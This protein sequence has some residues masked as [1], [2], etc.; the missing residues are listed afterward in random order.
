M[1]RILAL[2]LVLAL[3]LPVFSLAES[4]EEDLNIEDIIEDVDYDDEEED[5]DSDDGV[6][7][8]VL[9]AQQPLSEE[10]QDELKSVLESK[11]YVPTELDIGVYSSSDLLFFLK[12]AFITLLKAL[13][14]TF[15]A[16]EPMFLKKPVIRLTIPPKKLGIE[17][18]KDLILFTAH[19]TPLTIPFSIST[20]TRSSTTIPSV[21]SPPS[22]TISS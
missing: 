17:L 5:E 21:P 22:T 14:I 2:F 8:A 16:V 18:K 6:D 13:P 11:D 15:P 1:K 7:D 10:L 12:I 20:K 4:D 19:L 9:A 3:M